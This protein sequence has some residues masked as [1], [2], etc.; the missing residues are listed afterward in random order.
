M[1]FDVQKFEQIFLF[2]L[3]I[4]YNEKVGYFIFKWTQTHRALS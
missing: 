2:L 1:Y 3:L 4:T